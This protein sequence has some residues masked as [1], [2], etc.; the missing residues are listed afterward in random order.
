MW[1]LDMQKKNPIPGIASK[2]EPGSF[3][4][5]AQVTSSCSRNCPQPN[6]EKLDYVSSL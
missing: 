6:P 3:W 4:E 1:T 5:I 2:I